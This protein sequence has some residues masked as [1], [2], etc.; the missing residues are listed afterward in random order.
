MI[1]FI[2]FYTTFYLFTR[3]RIAYPEMHVE[4][5]GDKN[6][7][8]RW[9]AIWPV[10]VELFVFAWLTFEFYE[11]LTREKKSSEE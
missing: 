5:D 7:V 1:H 2:I 6:E 10:G 4:E 9:F 11:F 8:L 3:F